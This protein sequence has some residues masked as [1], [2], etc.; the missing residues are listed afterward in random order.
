MT[1]MNIRQE[2]DFFSAQIEAINEIVKEDMLEQDTESF[3]EDVQ[4]R[5]ERLFQQRR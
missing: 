4:R 1:Y 5:S 3:I 2:W